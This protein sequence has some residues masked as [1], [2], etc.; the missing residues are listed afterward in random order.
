[1]ASKQAVMY[2]DSNV[3]PKG[4]AHMYAQAHTRVHTRDNICPYNSYANLVA[5]MTCDQRGILA[6][7]FKLRPEEHGM[8]HLLILAIDSII[9]AINCQ[10]R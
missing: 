1:M 9:N 2:T 5:Y 8:A 4:A 10:S 7:V 6:E 3:K